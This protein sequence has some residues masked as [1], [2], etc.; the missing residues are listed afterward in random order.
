METDS[1][2]KTSPAIEQ[3]TEIKQPTQQ[4]QPEFM[5]ECDFHG[6]HK[7]GITFDNGKSWFCME[8]LYNLIKS[9]IGLSKKI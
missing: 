4:P 8:C 1:N 5:I 3:T 9:R 7:N 2:V 6:K